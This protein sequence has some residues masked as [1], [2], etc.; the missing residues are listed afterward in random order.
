[1]SDV[2]HAVEPTLPRGFVE[3][4][5]FWALT[6]QDRM[7]YKQKLRILLGDVPAALT[8]PS[9][10]DCH[11]MSEARK[12]RDAGKHITL[13]ITYPEA[14]GGDTYRNNRES[15]LRPKSVKK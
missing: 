13:V 1:M 4:E 3:P 14:A 15:A 7:A 10:E 2:S 8:C 12:M 9:P 11:T 6:R 5:V